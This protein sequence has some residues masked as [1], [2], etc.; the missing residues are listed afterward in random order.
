MR[1]SKNK[2]NLSTIIKRR[3]YYRD[4]LAGSGAFLIAF[5]V[6]GTLAPVE[7]SDATQEITVSNSHTGYY[8]TITIPDDTVSLNVEAT[9]AGQ[10]ASA[11]TSVNVKT[12]SPAGYQL[13]LS[14]ASSSDN[15]MYKD[16]SSSNSS[17]GY[18]SPVSGSLSSPSSLSQNN[19]GFTL[20]EVS[21]PVPA[22]TAVWAAVPTLNNQVSL[23]TV[24]AANLPDGTDYT[25]YYG[26]NASTALPEGSYSTT[27][28]YTAVSDGVNLP[29]MQDFTSAE[30]DA[31]STSQSIYLSDSRD[32]KLYRITKMAD[33]HCWMS[34]NLA[35]D[36]TDAY[37]NVRVLSVNDSN[38]TQNRT[39]AE[40]ITDGTASAHN[41]VQIYSGNADSTTTDCGSYAYCVT[42]DEPYGNL[43]NWTA[44][45]AGVGLQATTGTVT[46]SIC[47]KGWRLPDNTGDFSYANLMGKYSLPTTNTSGAGSSVQVAQQAP[48]YFPLA[49]SYY[50]SATSQ[51][52]RTT[53]YWSRTINSSNT[54][55]AYNAY[56]NAGDGSFFPQTNHNKYFGFSVRC[57]YG[58]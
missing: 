53:Y 29:T 57:V 10:L 9:S 46:E 24:S 18:F 21:T 12:N 15:N 40:N 43:Y 8:L 27:V 28:T 23:D 54:S 2:F 26:V 13:Y 6:A 7:S 49:G 33:G 16:G 39:L 31:M 11:A 38:V 36:G 25:I 50:G 30:C 52:G 35:L 22:D 3:N 17:V 32:D 47:P 51:Q 41:V 19:W 55:N 37:G 5:I 45:T 34:Q 48:L 1:T 20:T 44:A 14:T 56:F 4:F 42:S 58:S